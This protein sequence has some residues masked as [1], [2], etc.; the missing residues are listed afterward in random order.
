[1]SRGRNSLPCPLPERGRGSGD[2]R[3]PIAGSG[4]WN[5]VQYVQCRAFL[6]EYCATY[7]MGRP[8]RRGVDACRKRCREMAGDRRIWLPSPPRIGCPIIDVRFAKGGIAGGRRVLGFDRQRAERRDASEVSAGAEFM[9]LV[10][11][12][13]TSFLVGRG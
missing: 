3:A 7:G 5:L 1:M 10:I 6:V 11:G 8:G 13:I 12:G 4:K 2:G 9:R